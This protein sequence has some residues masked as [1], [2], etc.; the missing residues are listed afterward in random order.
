RCA[1]NHCRRGRSGT[2]R[3]WL[4]CLLRSLP[5]S[6]SFA[7]GSA[8]FERCRSSTRCQPQF[9]C[10]TSARHAKMGNTSMPSPPVHRVYAIQSAR[11]RLIF[12]YGL[13]RFAAAGVLTAIGLGLIDYLLRLHDP[14]ARWLISV[15]F[16][17]LI[18]T[19]FWKLVLPVLRSGKD[20]VGT[21]RRIE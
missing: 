10:P 3:L 21:A 7:S 15:A 13:G 19:S 20:L 17:A 16:V 8:C 14:V 11:H 1:L 12:L 4:V 9:G 2:P 6:G 5:W 18:I